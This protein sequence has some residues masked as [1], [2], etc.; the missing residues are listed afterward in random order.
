MTHADGSSTSIR[1]FVPTID[2]DSIFVVF[3]AMG[4]MASYYTALGNELAE[5][6]FNAFTVDLRGNGESSL[7]P[8]RNVDFGYKDELDHEYA[9]TLGYLKNRF[10]EK[11]IIVLGHSFGGQL[12]CLFAARDVHRIHQLVLVACCSVYWK[13]YSGINA[14]KTLVGTQYL[15]AIAEILG[16]LPGQ[17]VGF[18]GL[19]AKTV[20]RD[21]SHQGRTGNYVLSNDVF[22]YEAA[23]R[24]VA[25]PILAVSIEG[26]DLAPP[27]AVEHLINKLE[28]AQKKHIHLKRNDPYNDDY[29]HFN[30]ARKPKKMVELILK[31]LNAQ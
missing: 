20:I 24:N 13:G 26:D 6:G 23:L 29:N 4:V 10:P 19:E 22:D 15:R 30:W 28:S 3:P 17:K 27:S 25:I 11:R 8:S 16:Y 14:L 5:C 21:W 12:A 9:N 2:R 18:G 7:R 31:E 1:H